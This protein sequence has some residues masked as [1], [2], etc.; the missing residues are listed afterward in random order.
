MIRIEKCISEI[1]R[2]HI[3]SGNETDDCYKHSDIPEIISLL[4]K[5]MEGERVIAREERI[6]TEISNRLD[7]AEDSRLINFLADL[8]IRNNLKI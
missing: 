1:N 3:I 7:M 6:I 5:E 2:F 8:I 4:Q